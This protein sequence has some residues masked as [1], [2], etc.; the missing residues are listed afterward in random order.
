MTEQPTHVPVPAFPC[1]LSLCAGIFGFDNRHAALIALMT[2]RD[3]LEDAEHRA[4]VDA[5]L[6]CVFNDKD[7]HIYQA[8]MPLI[9]PLPSVFLTTAGTSSE[10]HQPTP[11]N[12]TPPGDD[13]SHRAITQSDEGS[14]AN[15]GEKRVESVP[16]PTAK[17]ESEPA[18]A[19][20]EDA[21]QPE[22]GEDSGMGSSQAAEHVP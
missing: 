9:F 1:Y 5:V 12:E 3:W 11:H 8:F 6:F 18:A 17:E 15:E 4:A 2:T 13:T 19:L 21:Q 22:Q 20:T 16:E 7:L 10:S 14:D